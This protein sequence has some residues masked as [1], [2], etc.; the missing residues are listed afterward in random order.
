[1]RRGVVLVAVLV[2]TALAGMIAAGLMFRMRAEVLASRAQLTGEQGYAAAISGLRFAAALL[3]EGPTEVERWYDNPDALRGRF[4]CDDGANRWYFTIYAYDPEG[5]D[6]VRYGL[7]DEAGK[8]NI[9]TADAETLLSLANMSSERVD[10]LLDYR[11]ADGET[12][13][14]GAEQNYYDNLPSAYLIK[15]G[16]LETL[17]ELLLVKGFN[18]TVLYGEDANLSGLLE[19]NEDDA[20]ESFPP[21]N[22]D[23]ALDVGLRNLATVY[24]HKL[25]PDDSR[26]NINAEYEQLGD[27]KQ[28]EL[29]EQT[30]HFIQLY[31]A[32]GNYFEHAADL[33]NMTYVVRDGHTE[34]MQIDADS[35]ISSG[36]SQ[37]DLALVLEKLIAIPP[38]GDDPERSLVNVNTAPAAVLSALEGIDQSLARRIVEA[39]S[40]LEG[41]D[42]ATIAWLYSEG[43]VDEE[44]FKQIAPLLTTRGYYFH[45]QCVGFAVPGGR[46]RIIEAVLD[47]SAGH[48]RIAYLRDITRL[49]LP[50]AID[51]EELE[52][53]G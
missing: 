14:Y 38:S 23:G 44:T 1:M 21:D 22:A 37:D 30:I 17:E 25:R 45:A 39:R 27:L 2:L 8:I 19:P 49:G 26:I 36:I 7:T 6:T 15:N 12:R 32:E 5:S 48:V 10:C 51:V 41:P 35:Q 9:N 11:D 43:V 31:R 47:I 3:E 40:G 53:A 18:G 46:F 24:G 16:P 13:A 4:V 33:L 34:P 28:S 29:D 42:K 20:E 52:G 50:F